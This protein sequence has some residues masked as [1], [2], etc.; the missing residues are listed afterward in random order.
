MSRSF[1]HNIYVHRGYVLNE[2]PEVSSEDR[3]N[4]KMLSNQYIETPITKVG[5]SHGR[6]I[7]QWKFHTWKDCLYI[8]IGPWVSNVRTP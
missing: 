4:I 1:Q 3:L 7:F 2:H 5:R 6:L 8:E